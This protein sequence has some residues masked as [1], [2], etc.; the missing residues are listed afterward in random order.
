MQGSV[1]DHDLLRAMTL[2]LVRLTSGGSQLCE[3]SPMD[4]HTACLLP[5]IVQYFVCHFQNSFSNSCTNPV[6]VNSRELFSSSVLK[7]NKK[8][9]I[10]PSWQ[11]HFNQQVFS[12]THFFFCLLHANSGELQILPFLNF[13]Y[14]NRL[15]Y[16][17]FEILYA[18]LYWAEQSRG[19]TESIYVSWF[20]LSVLSHLQQLMHVTSVLLLVE[21]AGPAERSPHFSHEIR[22]YHRKGQNSHLQ[23]GYTAVAETSIGETSTSVQRERLGLFSVQQNS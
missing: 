22:M 14:V 9:L 18:N 8:R 12:R 15:P 13:A 23:T 11:N 16:M 10:F 17:A 4:F 3:K 21:A 2:Q 19:V 1:K 5:E 7:N 20:I 6:S